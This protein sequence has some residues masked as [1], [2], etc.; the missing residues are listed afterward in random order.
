MAAFLF[1]GVFTMKNVLVYGALAVIK[2]V[3]LGAFL[4]TFGAIAWILFG[5]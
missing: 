1:N 4:A 5:A 3:A 2:L